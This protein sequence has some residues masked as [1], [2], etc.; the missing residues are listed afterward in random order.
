MAIGLSLPFIIGVG[1]GVAGSTQSVD[2]A[3]TLL[4]VAFGLAILYL[5]G[6]PVGAVVGLP[7]VGIDWDQTGYGLST[8]LV[9]V[10]ATLWYVAVFLLPIVFFGFL[11]ALPTGS[12]QSTAI[13]GTFWGI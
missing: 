6:L 1:I 4:N 10:M 9:V 3:N 8:W 2:T 12:N 7:R 5:I 13:T 11:L